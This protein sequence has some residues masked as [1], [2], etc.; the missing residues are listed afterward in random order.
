MLIIWNTG[1]RKEKCHQK[2]AL[3]NLSSST[4]SVKTPSPKQRLR[5]TLLER[6]ESLSPLLLRRSL[7]K[8][9]VQEDPQPTAVEP[10]VSQDEVADKLN[11][12]WEEKPVESSPEKQRPTGISRASSFLQRLLSPVRNASFGRTFSLRSSFLSGNSD[13]TEQSQK[14][15][16]K[17][18]VEIS[19]VDSNRNRCASQASPT[20]HNSRLVPRSPCSDVN[21]KTPNLSKS[22]S[23]TSLTKSDSIPNYQTATKS[24]SLKS[25][26]PVSKPKRTISSSSIKNGLKSPRSDFSAQLMTSPL[27]GSGDVF[28]FD[29]S[30]VD[31]EKVDGE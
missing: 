16:S 3:R 20:E 25:K 6:A 9:S 12:N 7:K 4:K 29:T 23:R 5:R 19:R 22:Q 11:S 10:K 2:P 28:A 14:S 8:K 21:Q 18:E 27:E 24:S 13:S 30:E 31:M 1:D 15:T 17:K 26:P